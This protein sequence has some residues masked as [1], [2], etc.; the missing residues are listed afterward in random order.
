M[1]SPQRM[2]LAETLDP[3]HIGTGEFRLGRV[4]STIVREAGTNLPKIPGSSIAGVARAYTAMSVP[5]AYLRK[6]GDELES[7]AGKGGPDGAGHC[8]KPEC[9]VCT[10]Y[11]FSKRDYSFQG[12]AQFGDARILLFPVYSIA[13]PVWV[14]CPSS[15]VDF[16][17]VGDDWLEW[18]NKLWPSDGSP[19]VLPLKDQSR[20]PG[21][22]NLGWLY[23]EKYTGP[24]E[25]TS[26][27]EWT[28]PDGAKQKCLN[29]ILDRI[30]LVSDSLFSVIVEDQL[31]VRTSVS[32]SP[33]TGAAESGA[34]FTFEAIPRACFLFF[35]VTCLDPAFF[36]VPTRNGPAE[37]Q[38]NQHAAE[39]NDIRHNV[40]TG[41]RLI[42][43]L[44]IGG[45]NTRGMGR[46]RVL[47]DPEAV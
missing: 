1:A 5:K 22:I 24:G 3:V 31:E 34:L 9:P 25:F 39:L 17:C 16:G 36:R 8:G 19:L 4:D 46:L 32:I 33:E 41:L 38:R 10:T 29:A 15:L 23:L 27:S 42:E 12:L 40:E 14:T 44:G 11:G 13:G 26:P 47:L 20:A 7:C 28:W 37:V 18:N 35:H 2:Y 43:H 30:Y 6:N 45:V 21:R